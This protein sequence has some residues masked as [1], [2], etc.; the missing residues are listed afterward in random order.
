M[1]LQATEVCCIVYIEAENVSAI[2]ACK[3]ALWISHL[4]GDLCIIGLHV[5]HRDNH[6]VIMLAQ[7][8][9]FHAKKNHIQVKYHFIRDVLNSK[10]IKLV[11]GHTNDKPADLLMKGVHCRQ[12]IGVG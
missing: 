3:E 2:E 7:N 12:M 10:S 8:P 9:V 5:L 4:M 6:N 11:K 1:D